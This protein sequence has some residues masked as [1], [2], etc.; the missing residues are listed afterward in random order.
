MG[1]EHSTLLGTV[2]GTAL[3]VAVNL[4]LQD[5]LKT[6]VCAMIGAVVSFCVSFSLKWIVRRFRK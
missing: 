4:D 2:S 1:N 5:I 3:T 6:A